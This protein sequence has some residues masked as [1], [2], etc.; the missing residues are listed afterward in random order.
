[1]KPCLAKNCNT[2]TGAFFVLCRD[3]WRVIPL[4]LKDK[5]NE[6][7]RIRQKS[8][9]VYDSA[10]KEAIEFIERLKNGLA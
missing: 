8:P 1:V 2:E 9:D 10:V 3:H 4:S 5:V 7:Y 6:A